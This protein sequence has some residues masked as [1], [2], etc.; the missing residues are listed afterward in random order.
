[1]S[2]F[3]LIVNQDCLKQWIESVIA[4]H[5]FFEIRHYSFH[6]VRIRQDVT[7]AFIVLP[8]PSIQFYK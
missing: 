1:M 3:K 5:I 6:T 2:D 4:I 8:C 7:A